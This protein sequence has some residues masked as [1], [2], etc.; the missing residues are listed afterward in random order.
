[1]KKYE[2]LITFAG[3]S[4]EFVIYEHPIKEFVKISPGLNKA[5]KEYG[6]KRKEYASSVLNSVRNKETKEKQT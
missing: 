1:M 5:L 3:G 2:Y 4:T 6:K